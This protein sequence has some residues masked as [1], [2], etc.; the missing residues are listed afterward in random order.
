MK[1]RY[2]ELPAYTTRDASEIRELLHPDVHAALGVRHQS[3]AEARVAPGAATVLHRH[4]RS[5]EIYH[6]TAGGGRMTLG[7]ETFTLRAGDTVCITPGTPHRLE[8]T[9]D[10]PLVVL[11]AC[12]PPYA[13]DDT[14]LL[15]AP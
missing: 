8:N 5:E 14:E 2:A 9:G 1:T 6:I 13:H 12:S 15:E 7:E 11:C 3:L 4:H 10:T